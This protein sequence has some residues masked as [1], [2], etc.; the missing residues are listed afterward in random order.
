MYYSVVHNTGR[1]RAPPEEKP[2]TKKKKQKEQK[3]S[4]RAI[5]PS[6]VAAKGKRYG[7]KYS[8]LWNLLQKKREGEHKQKKNKKNKKNKKHNKI[9]HPA[10]FCISYLQHVHYSALSFDLNFFADSEFR[11]DYFVVGSSYFR[12]AATCLLSLVGCLRKKRRSICIP[13]RK[14]MK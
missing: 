10:P 9:T 1:R 12:A 2:N 3:K 11:C 14:S 8:L 13:T 5:S 4:S 7:Q 6:H